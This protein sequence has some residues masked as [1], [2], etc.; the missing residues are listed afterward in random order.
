MSLNKKK[1]FIIILQNYIFRNILLS[2][3]DIIKMDQ[4]SK[5]YLCEQDC[6][7][8]IVPRRRPQV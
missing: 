5:L 7:S 8:Y 1:I 3:K 2:L 4:K 6:Q